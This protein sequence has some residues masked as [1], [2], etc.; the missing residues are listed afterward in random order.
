MHILSCAASAN[1]DS[2][3]GS[4]TPDELIFRRFR[5]LT[6]MGKSRL[7]GGFFEQI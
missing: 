1:N 3:A 6:A 7:R 4:E 5:A 2:A